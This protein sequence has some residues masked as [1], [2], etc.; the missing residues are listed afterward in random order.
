MQV[1][2]LSAG[3]TIGMTLGGAS[4]LL[5][6]GTIEE[7]DDRTVILVLHNGNQW[8][9]LPRRSD[10]PVVGIIWAST[11]TQDWVTRSAA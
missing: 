2:N 4:N 6:R 8:V 1:N 3:N 5:V 7:A 10:E 11:P 9:M